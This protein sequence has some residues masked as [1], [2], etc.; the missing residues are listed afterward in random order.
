M[1]VGG[2]A[3]R[4]FAV[5][6]GRKSEI[7]PCIVVIIMYFAN[8]EPQTCAVLSA[9]TSPT[10]RVNK[11]R[12]RIPGFA[13]RSPPPLPKF[14][15]RPTY[16]RIFQKIEAPSLEKIDKRTFPT[17]PSRIPPPPT[18][19]T[20]FTGPFPE[21]NVDSVGQSSENLPA[22]RPRRCTSKSATAPTERGRSVA[23]RCPRRAR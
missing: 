15:F 18:P 3:P 12:R 9:I 11:I 22:Q 21:N 17:D 23:F 6:A 16:F 7:C 4:G 1:C 14:T 13:P 2:A 10:C 5:D 19:R 8:K 20:R